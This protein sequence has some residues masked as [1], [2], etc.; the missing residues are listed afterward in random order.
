MCFNQW[1]ALLLF[2]F[3][4]S[5]FFLIQTNHF[6]NQYWQ[7]CL[8]KQNTCHIQYSKETN[9]RILD[10]SRLSSTPRIRPRPRPSRSSSLFTTQQYVSHIKNADIFEFFS[11]IRILRLFKLTRPSSGL[12]ILL[13]TFRVSQHQHQL[14][15][16]RDLCLPTSLLQ[17]KQITSQI[18]DKSEIK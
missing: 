12:K 15:R 10:P 18:C 16:S 13:Q 7:N 6:S 1:N 11:I 8:L 4:Q 2:S 14:S 5:N 3:D 9:H 17:T